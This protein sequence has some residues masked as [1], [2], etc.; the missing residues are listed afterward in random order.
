MTWYPDFN[1]F[2][3]GDDSNAAYYRGQWNG[4]KMHGAGTYYWPEKNQRFEGKSLLLY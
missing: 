4:N 2:E 3:N 1:A